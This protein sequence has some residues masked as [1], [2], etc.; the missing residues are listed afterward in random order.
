MLL[1]VF[2]DRPPRLTYPSLPMP[3]NGL[4]TNSPGLENNNTHRRITSNWSGQMCRVS[5]P[6]FAAFVLSV[7][8]SLISSQQPSAQS[9]QSL[10]LTSP[11]VSIG[12]SFAPGFLN[13][14][15]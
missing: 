4:N 15:R 2:A 7:S 11:G 3:V 6:D 13:L 5:S 1:P 8:V 12:V 9:I 14:I 10:R